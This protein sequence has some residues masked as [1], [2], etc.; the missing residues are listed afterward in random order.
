M[1]GPGFA[2]VDFA[3]IKNTQLAG[4]DFPVDLQFRAEFFNIFNRANFGLPDPT[5]FNDPGPFTPTFLATRRGRAGRIS[6]TVS[7][8][9]QIQVALKI[10]F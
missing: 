8:S 5:L 2:S 7:T 10:I 6:E 4:G 3:V 1:R 9:R